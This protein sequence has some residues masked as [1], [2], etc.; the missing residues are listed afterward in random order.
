MCKMITH[1]NYVGRTY[2]MHPIRNAFDGVPFGANKHGILVALTEDDLHACESGIMLNL[3]E[4]AY[5]GLTPPKY[6]NKSSGPRSLNANL[7]SCQNC[8]VGQQRRTLAT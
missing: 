3:A 7:V 6:L 5:G 8:P 4:V 1:G 2:S